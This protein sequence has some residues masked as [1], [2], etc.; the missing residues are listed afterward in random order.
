MFLI[1]VALLR[2]IVAPLYLIGS[3]LISYLSALG[4]GVIVFQFILGQQLHWSLPGLS[5]ILLVAIGADYNMLLISRI[6]DESPHGVRVGRHPHGGF[7]RRCDHVGGSDLRRVDVR[8]AVRQHQHDGPRPGFIIG[9]GIVLDTFLVRT[10]TVPALAALI[11]QANWWPSRLGARGPQRRG[12]RKQTPNAVLAARIR[13]LKDSFGRKT[14]DAVS[15]PLSPPP[16]TAPTAHDG[17]NGHGSDELRGD[18]ALPLFSLSASVNG[19]PRRLTDAQQDTA[20]AT[21]IGDLPTHALPLFG[22]DAQREATSPMTVN[23]KDHTNGHTNRSHQWSH[24]RPNQ[25]PRQTT[26]PAS[27]AD[28]RPRNHAA[29]PCDHQRHLRTRAAAVRPNGLR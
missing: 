20:L 19:H 6:R 26:H 24:Q 3:V 13:W 16:A 12:G 10:I 1:L 14:G 25:R 9:I 2:A 5:F 29:L 21:A 23:G 11:G 27:S 22:P 28:R 18:H 15:A 4:I 7:D 17:L 8:P